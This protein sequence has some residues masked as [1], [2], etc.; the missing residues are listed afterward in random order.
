MAEQTQGECAGRVS[1]LLN[2]YSSVVQLE[3]IEHLKQAG[4]SE[5]QALQVLNHQKSAALTRGD[6]QNAVK[7]MDLNPTPAQRAAGNY[8]KGHFWWKGIPITIETPVGATRKGVGSDGVRWQITMSDHYGYIKRTK[9]EADGDHIDVFFRHDLGEGGVDS[10]IVFIV[11]QFLDGK[12]DEHKAVLGCI[13]EA[14]ARDTYTRNYNRNW[15]G[16]HSITPMLLDD[17]KKW[18]DYGNTANPAKR[19]LIK[20]AVEKRPVRDDARDP[21]DR[22]DCPSCGTMHERGDSGYC[23]NCH[24]PW[25]ADTKTKKAFEQIAAVLKTAL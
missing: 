22:E 3:A 5:V 15:R 8:R 21:A 9:S 23:N 17:F 24:E 6:I 20:V 13:S 16:L 2:A 10:E 4:L 7:D 11:N 12:F 25:P 14:Q 18:I 19:M 1:Q